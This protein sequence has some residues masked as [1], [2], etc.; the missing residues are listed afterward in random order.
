MLRRL[1]LG[2]A[3]A[4]AGVGS[5]REMPTHAADSRPDCVGRVV[6]LAAD[7]S[8]CNVNPPQRL[9]V[10]GYTRRECRDHG[11]W[12]RVVDRRC[13]DVDY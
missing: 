1:A 9:D 13:F 2:L 10:V 5:A 8:P 3:L 12:F 4:A 11:G 7:A 6:V